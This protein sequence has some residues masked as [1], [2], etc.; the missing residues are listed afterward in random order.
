MHYVAAIYHCCAR[1]PLP[2]EL[3]TL[4]GEEPLLQT[5]NRI[6]FPCSDRWF[7]LL[8]KETENRS[9]ERGAPRFEQII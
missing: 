5:A 8:V 7:N 4:L 3:I 1:L 9:T 2:E 6:S